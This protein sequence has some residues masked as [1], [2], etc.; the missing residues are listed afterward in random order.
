MPRVAPAL[1]LL[2]CLTLPF[3]LAAQESTTVGGYGEVHYTNPSR[4]N[5]PAEVNL[6]RFIVYLAHTFNDRLAFRSELEVEDAKVEGGSA[7]GEVALEQAYLDYRLSD[8]LTLRT[9]LVLPPVGIVNETHE[10]PTFNGVD[11]PAF[12]HDVIP[13]T[14]REIGVGIVGTLPVAEGLGYR[15][16]LV[17]GLRADGFSDDAGLRGGRQEGRE[18]TFANPSLTG[19]LEWVRPGLRVGG[20]FWYGG[21]TGA[22]TLLGTGTF[23][24]PVALL[25]AD[26][27]YER[28][29]FA[30]RGVVATIGVSDADTING[31]YGTAVGSR[32][33]G[34]YIEGAYDVLRLLSVGTSQRLNAFVR[35]ERYDT[36]AAVPAG[37]T[38]D[39]GFARRITTFGLAYKPTFNTVFKGD[40]EVRRTVAGT[41]EGETLRLGVGYQF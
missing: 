26:V 27:R 37:T 6:R 16:Y 33:T 34:G 24:A 39:Q 15:L 10:P 30:L 2:A 31:L 7:G 40:Y 36:Q 23:D 11:R 19:R 18:A 9:G 8:R 35:H 12:D 1:A 41:G 14:W 22:D 21:T 28:G 25:S 4:P 29:G 13:T 17:N 3:T 20:S 5:T 32:I 38:R